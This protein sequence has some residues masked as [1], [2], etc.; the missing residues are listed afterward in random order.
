MFS[1]PII[2]IVTMVVVV[3]NGQYL[4]KQSGNLKLYVVV[5]PA[6]IN[7]Q[8]IGELEE[9]EVI[10]LLNLYMLQE[11][12]Y[13]EEVIMKQGLV[14]LIVDLLVIL[15]VQT[16]VLTGHVQVKRELVYYHRTQIVE[17]HNIL[18]VPQEHQNVHVVFVAWISRV[19]M[20]VL[21]M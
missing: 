14:L 1:I 2:G 20:V 13:E 6:I 5:D 9:R 10:M 21:H 16:M 12:V 8:V 15:V 19:G 18:Y 4:Q 3:S 17:P 11:L 7:L